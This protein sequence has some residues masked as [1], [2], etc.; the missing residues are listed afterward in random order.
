MHW[1]PL[2]WSRLTYLPPELPPAS[3]S[4]NSLASGS[5]FDMSRQNINCLPDPGPGIETQMQKIQTRP[6]SDLLCLRSIP[7][8]EDIFKE[9]F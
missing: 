9:F 4:S 7:E 5:S 1:P 2:G 3:K 6:G 8:K